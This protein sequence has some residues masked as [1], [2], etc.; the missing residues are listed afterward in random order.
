M[1]E[2]LSESNEEKKKDVVKVRVWKQP[3]EISNILDL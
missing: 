3:I 1:I 2:S